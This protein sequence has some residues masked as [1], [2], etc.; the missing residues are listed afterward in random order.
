MLKQLLARLDSESVRKIYG[1]WLPVITVVML[2]GV[3]SLNTRPTLLG[4]ICADF[5]IRLLLSGWLCGLYIGLS[6][7][8]APPLHQ[9]AHIGQPDDIDGIE[10]L[11]LLGG[12]VFFGIASGWLTYWII[13]WLLPGF[14]QIASATIS[15]LNAL[16]IFLP[17]AANY[18]KW[19]YHL[20]D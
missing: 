20:Y 16:I 1:V 13:N 3:A 10:K 8:F 9:D 19:G 11:F 7:L 15:A 18:R 4:S 14:S 6:R 12:A 17:L 5:V 2:L